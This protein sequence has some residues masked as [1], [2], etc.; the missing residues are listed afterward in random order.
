MT[1]LV[2]L[3]AEGDQWIELPPRLAARLTSSAFAMLGRC[4]RN[5]FA[6]CFRCVRID[7]GRVR[8]VFSPAIPSLEGQQQVAVIGGHKFPSCRPISLQM[9]KQW[10]GEHGR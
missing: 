3:K 1:S 5:A 8:T 2:P 6:W 10:S 9:S 7:F 4:V